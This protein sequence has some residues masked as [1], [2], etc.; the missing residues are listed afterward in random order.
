VIKQTIEIA[1][2]RDKQ[3]HRGGEMKI[4]ELKQKISINNLNF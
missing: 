2:Q 4:N 1:G 3:T